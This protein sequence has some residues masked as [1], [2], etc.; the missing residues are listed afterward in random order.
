MSKMGWIATIGLVGAALLMLSTG[1]L[2]GSSGASV[3]TGGGLVAASSSVVGPSFNFSNPTPTWNT[4]NLCTPVQTGGNVSCT[5]SGGGHRGFAPAITAGMSGCGCQGS[6]PLTYNF[7]S[8]YLNYTVN[9]SNLN[10]QHVYLNFNGATQ[11]I[12]INVVGCMGGQLNI[13]VKGEETVNVNLKTSG[14]KV[15]LTIY[16]NNDHYYGTISGSH[17]SIWTTFVSAKFKL[18]ECPAQN[19]SVTDSYWV[20][21]SGWGNAQG[22]VFASA[23]GPGSALNGVSTGGWN[24]VWFA[25]TTD[26]TCSWTYAPASTCSHGYGPADVQAAAR[27]EE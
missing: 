27:T 6:T 21:V 1:F 20:G 5:Y 14:A 7:S 4:G 10:N 2:V 19:N 8:R 3:A 24:S 9:V 25:N 16:G 12:T 17:N 23:V 18:N 15:V 13:T 22:I 26:F 11:N